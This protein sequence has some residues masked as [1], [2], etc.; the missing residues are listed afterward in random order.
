MKRKFL[1]IIS[2]M[3]AVLSVFSACTK[4]PSELVGDDTAEGTVTVKD[5]LIINGVNVTDYT[6]VYDGRLV[7]GSSAAQKY[8]NSKM[9]QEYD[10]E[11]STKTS[12]ADGNQIFIGHKGSDASM[13]TF[14][15]S[16]DGGMLGFDGKNIY[17]L[18]KDRAGLFGVID[19][20]F[21]KAV[22]QGEY[23]EI[24][25]SQTEK[26]ALKGDSL[27]VMSYNVLYDP[28]HDEEQTQPRDIAALAEFLKAQA[29]DVLG[30]QETQ[31]FHKEAILK[32][33]PNYE[34]YEGVVL[35]GGAKQSNMIFWNADK[36]KLVS[37]GFQYLTS[38]PYSESKIEESNSYRGF[39][40]VVLESRESGKQ[41]MF[42][43]VHI[44]YRDSDGNNSGDKVKLARLKQAQY[45]VKFL[46]NKK[47]DT[48][49]IVLVG[50]FN[51]VPDSEALNAID[52]SK[53]IDR[54]ALVAKTKGDVSG[55]L[56][57]SN[58]TERDNKYIFDHIFVTSDRI[59]TQYYSVIDADSKV[60]GYYLSDHLPVVANIVIY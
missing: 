56:T 51:S 57:K 27:K 35:K 44:T 60:N 53:R 31:N 29:P 34:C 9:K 12:V 42:V 14:L 28:Y 3:L 43:D 50:D 33:M 11:L 21:A 52:N 18:S 7:V 59:V 58:Q 5:A 48:M 40:Y 37:K 41:F 32:A 54:T 20:F 38:T 13:E 1:V 4:A 39:S 23:S 6:I 55:T 26:V 36:F 24:T 16:C 30:T 10:V 25:V 8:F 15:S 22:S 17:I 47:Y 49:P 46:E 45:L 2:L 19:A